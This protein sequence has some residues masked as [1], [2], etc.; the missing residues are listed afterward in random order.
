VATRRGRDFWRGLIQEVEYGASIVDV[1]RRHSV[2]TQGIYRWRR[3]LALSAAHSPEFLPV[4][5]RAAR[6]Q[7]SPGFLD[8]VVGSVRLH[9]E[10]GTNVDY[11]AEVVRAL[12]RSC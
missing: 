2:Q 8:V 10:I 12:N 9:V 1:A 11:I 4:V 6:S 3:K 7:T 5:V